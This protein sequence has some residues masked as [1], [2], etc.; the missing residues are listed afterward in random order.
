LKYYFHP[1]ALAEHKQNIR[2]YQTQQPNL[3]KQYV[4]AFN[5]TIDQVCEMPQR[6][7]TARSPNIRRAALKTFPFHIIYREHLL[8]TN[9]TQ[10]Q[11]LAIAHQRRKPHYWANR[12]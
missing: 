1:S 12:D 7:R 3:G 10:I 4:D 5:Q 11:I 6:F 8:Q 9:I 2:Y